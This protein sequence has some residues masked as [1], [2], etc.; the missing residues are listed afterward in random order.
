[1]NP[2]QNYAEA[3]IGA[4]EPVNLAQVV[5]LL[6]IF[7]QTIADHDELRST[8][9]SPSTRPVELIGLAIT[10]IDELNNESSTPIASAVMATV[11]QFLTVVVEN[12]RAKQIPVIATKLAEVFNRR[13]GA[14]HIEVTSAF[15]LSD[16]EKGE[17]ISSLSRGGARSMEF[18]WQVDSEL[19]GG[20]VVRC[21]DRIVDASIRDSIARLERELIRA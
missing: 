21:G 12:H 20:F 6:S 4:I 5:Q 14:L 1:M 10:I 11:K 13:F 9:A 19:L 16:S 3:L 17:L 2:A 7:G 15:L 18:D 8:L